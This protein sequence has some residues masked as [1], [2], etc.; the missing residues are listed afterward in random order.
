MISVVII[1]R[2]RARQLG[3]ISLPSLLAQDYGEFEVIL[4][5]ASDTADSYHVAESFR[6][7]F[8]QRRIF[9]RFFSAPRKGSSSQRN[10]A[11]SE[12]RG[13]LVFFIDDDSH[14][15]PDGIRSLHECFDSDSLIMGAGLRVFEAPSNL[16]DAGSRETVSAF[17][18]RRSG[19]RKKRVVSLSGSAKGISAPAGPAEWLSGCSMAFRRELF[20]SFLFNEKLETFGPYAQCEDIEFSHRIFRTYNYP[21]WVAPRGYVVHIPAPEER[22]VGTEKKAAT[23]FYNRYLTMQVTAADHSFL[24][25]AGFYWSV[26][27]RGIALSRKIGFRV[28]LNGYCMAYRKIRKQRH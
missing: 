26:L 22:I 4:W 3:D 13:D 5:D 21:L 20:K 27:R 11:L 23:L 6:E 8:S 19:Y 1:T 12:C 25:I 14:V 18:E 7:R 2:N 10:D 17:V 15:S 24:G 9:F 16:Q 28:V